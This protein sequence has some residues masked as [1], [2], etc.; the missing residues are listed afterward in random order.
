MSDKPYTFD[1][2]PE[3]KASLR[4]EA[5]QFTAMSVRKISIMR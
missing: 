4:L 1:E 3:Q 5:M 2:S